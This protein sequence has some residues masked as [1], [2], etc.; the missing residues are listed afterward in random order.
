MFKVTV[1]KSYKDGTED[2]SIFGRTTIS[3][4]EELYHQEVRIAQKVVNYI[5]VTEISVSLRKGQREINDAVIFPDRP[6][7][8]KVTAMKITEKS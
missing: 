8:F 5:P 2:E 4:A 1:L 7:K 6:A 3:K